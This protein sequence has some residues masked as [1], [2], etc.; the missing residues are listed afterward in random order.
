MKEI[1]EDLVGNKLDDLGIFIDS[2]TYEKEEGQNFLRIALDSSDATRYIKLDEVVMATRII[3]KII[4]KNDEKIGIEEEY[5]L[6]VY[7]KEKGDVE[8]EQ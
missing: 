5:I 7:A 8:N 1:I 4:D 6:D 2:V 3:N